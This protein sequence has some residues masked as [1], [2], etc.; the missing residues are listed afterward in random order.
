MN[1]NYLGITVPLSFC[2]A[3]GA[4]AGVLGVLVLAP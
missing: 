2:G 4:A 1:A 3:A